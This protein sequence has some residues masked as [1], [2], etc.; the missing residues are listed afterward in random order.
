MT[1]LQEQRKSFIESECG[2]LGC[3]ELAQ[4]LSEGFTSCCEAAGFPKSKW[5]EGRECKSADAPACESVGDSIRKF[6]GK[7]KEPEQ[8]ELQ[9]EFFIRPYGGPVHQPN[10][11]PGLIWQILEAVNIDHGGE[12]TKEQAVEYIKLLIPAIKDNPDDHTFEKT[13]YRVVDAIK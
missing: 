4:A 9:D 6:F 5:L 12:I 8:E 10:R 3:G 7:K 1:A 11:Y 13:L 2:K